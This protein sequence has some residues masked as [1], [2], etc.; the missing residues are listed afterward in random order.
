[1]FADIC[2]A[3]HITGLLVA[4]VAEVASRLGFGRGA[5]RYD[6]PDVLLPWAV[7]LPE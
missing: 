7:E 3:L 5:A 6:V 1:M 4:G 2:F